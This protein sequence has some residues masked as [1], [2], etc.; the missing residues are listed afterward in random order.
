MRACVRVWERMRERVL[1]PPLCALWEALLLSCGG[2]DDACVVPLSVLASRGAEGDVCP[3]VG[4][5]TQVPA[6]PSTPP[7]DT[8]SVDAA[9][10]GLYVGTTDAADPMEQ[11]CQ[12]APDADECRVYED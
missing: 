8:T 11:F 2:R 6:T 12:S 4:D 10:A 1:F 5:I 3:R 9:A 7:Q